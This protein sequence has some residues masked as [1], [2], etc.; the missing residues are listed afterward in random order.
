MCN[1]CGWL[2]HTTFAATIYINMDA[3]QTSSKTTGIPKKTFDKVTTLIITLVSQ[4]V[5]TADFS[6][7]VSKTIIFE[8]PDIDIS[9]FQIFYFF[10][11]K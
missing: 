10:S 9:L 4:F 8:T 1:V 2:A 5:V 11:F 7:H 6:T 3:H